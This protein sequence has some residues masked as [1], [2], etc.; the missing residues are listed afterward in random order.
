MKIISVHKSPI[1]SNTFNN[2][3]AR[4]PKCLSNDFHRITRLSF[5]AGYDVYLIQI[6]DGVLVCGRK[7]G[8]VA[9]LIQFT[10]INPVHELVRFTA[11]RTSLKY[12]C[13]IRSAKGAHVCAFNAFAI[14][15]LFETAYLRTVQ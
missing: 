10:S 5:R 15:A 3:V 8:A 9:L 2:I 6:A 14:G 13:N 11:E 4:G 12:D 7:R 1:D